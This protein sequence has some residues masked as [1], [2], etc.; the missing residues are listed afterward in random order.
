MLKEYYVTVVIDHIIILFCLF[1]FD[2]TFFNVLYLFQP[3]K[4]KRKEARHKAVHH[5]RRTTK[6]QSDETH[7]E[8]EINPAFRELPS[9]CLRMVNKC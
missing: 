5:V 4:K 8:P 3:K 7:R 1:L 2:V 9:L 6:Q